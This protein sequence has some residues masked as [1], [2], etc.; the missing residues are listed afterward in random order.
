MRI[1]SV[2]L[3]VWL[4]IGSIAAV[5]RGDYKRPISCSTISTIA[6]TIIAGPFNYA[7]ANWAINCTVQTLSGNCL[8]PLAGL[9][10]DVGNLW[11]I[12]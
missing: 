10:V 3:A 7:G 2:L 11:H 8:L 4:F 5:Q 12:K 9:D 6:I 1:G